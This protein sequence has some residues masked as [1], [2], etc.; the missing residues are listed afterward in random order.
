MW[1]EEEGGV[2]GT[3]RSAEPQPGGLLSS[4]SAPGVPVKVTN[5]KDGTTHRTS[6]ELFL[7]LNE[8]A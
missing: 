3:G 6:L 5:T 4:L 2:V 7:Y 1:V 8:V